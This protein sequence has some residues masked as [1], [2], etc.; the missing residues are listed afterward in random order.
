MSHRDVDLVIRNDFDM[1]KIL[2]FLI[3][4]LKTVDG[5]K[6]SAVKLIETVKEYNLKKL[7]HCPIRG[8]ID[9]FKEVV[10]N[11]QV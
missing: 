6:N 2:K 9:P 8:T 7:S 5:A 4:N 11:G 10:M 3:Y 1:E